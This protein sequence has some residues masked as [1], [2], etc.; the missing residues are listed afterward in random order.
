[1]KCVLMAL[2]ALG[3]SVAFA[4]EEKPAYEDPNPFANYDPAMKSSIM[5]P[6]AVNWSRSADRQI[7]ARTEESVLAE[8][9]SSEENAMALLNK[10]K[11]AYK[12]EAID[13]TQIAA[14]TQWVMGKEPFCLWFWK[15]SP[16]EGRKIWVAALQRKIAG[17][18]DQY[19]RTFCRQQLDLCE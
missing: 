14:V 16:A 9:V 12:S 19:V 5:S 4:E 3:M 10:V 11:P 6:L 17:T 13:L 18:D 1:M 7:A 8:I 2:L 15:P